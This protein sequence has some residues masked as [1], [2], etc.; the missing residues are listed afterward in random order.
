MTR[1]P[2]RPQQNLRSPS[3]IG[4][5][6]AEAALQRIEASD[7]EAGK[8]ARH[9]HEVLTWGEGPAMLRQA[10]L[11]AW[12]WY[13]LPTK[14]IDGEPGYMARLAGAASLLMD[15]LGLHRYAAICRSDATEAVHA[16]FDERDSEGLAALQAAMRD[17][18]ITPPDLDDFQ[19]T[20]HM[21]INE[22]DA[23]TAVEDAL[24]AAIAAGELT[25]GA[26]GWKAAQRRVA[27]S[28]LDCDHIDQPGQSWRT[29]LVTERLGRWV[30]R[31]D[32][33]SESVGASR[34]Q[35]ANRLLH[36][37]DLPPG[38]AAALELP[39]WLLRRFGAEQPLTQAGNLRVAFV[40][41]V[42]EDCPW[43]VIES[44]PPYQ[45][46]HVEAD[47]MILGAL[48]RWLQRANALRKRHNKLRRTQAGAKMAEDASSAWQ[49]L[50]Q[51]L[52][53]SDWD[54]FVVENAAL[55]MLCNG[56][57][58]AKADLNAEVAKM[59]TECGWRSRH[60]G[61]QLTPSANAASWAFSETLLLWTACGFLASEGNWPNER[62]TLTD[63]GTAAALTRLRHTAT[64]PDNRPF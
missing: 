34:A 14:Y 1:S 28:A 59:A 2:T 37:I 20:G 13:E 39:M 55:T 16:A 8:D 33:M 7:S 58:M 10:R 46:R 61:E 52:F 3:D 45:Q 56:G 11:Q 6:E 31:G 18:G 15:E 64:G 60:D 63:V 53:P 62:L 19:W 22:A 49:R 25:V 54:G 12:L 32:F 50:T 30:D 17:S 38:L 40:R 26:R 41:E 35:V 24:E 47:D 44:P 4:E 48:R 57:Q 5:S 23:Y 9:V 27:S 21:G 29:V 51:H 43:R 36:P 42:H